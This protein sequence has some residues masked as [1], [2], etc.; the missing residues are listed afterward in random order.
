VTDAGDSGTRSRAAR[1]TSARGTS[2]RKT[3]AAWVEAGSRIGFVLLLVV[4]CAALGL[5]I[6]WPLWAFATGAR[7]A[8]TITVLAVGA[9]GLL[10]LAVRSA[11]RRRASTRDPSQPSRSTAAGL[12][13]VL[14]VL[15]GLAGAWTAAALLVR[16]I[17]V[18]GAAAVALWAGLLWLL[19]RARRAA[20]SRKAAAV[21]AENLSE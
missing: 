13:T 21:P 8:Y 20:R 4:G 12:L 14:M 6:A 10:F 18:L 19:G 2:A 11:R 3:V 1:G 17:W 15:V 16:G 5:A 7:Q 9:A